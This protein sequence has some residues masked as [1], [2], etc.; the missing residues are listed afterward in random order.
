MDA[1][2]TCD[3]QKYCSLFGMS[4]VTGN[5]PEQYYCLPGLQYPTPV[6]S[7]N[8]MMCEIGTYCPA[9]HDFPELCDATYFCDKY[10]QVETDVAVLSDKLCRD[11]FICATGLSFGTPEDVVEGVSDFCPKGNWCQ[12]GVPTACLAGTY[13]NSEQK[14]Q[15]A[16]GDCVVCPYG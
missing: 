5:C 1:C 15:N 7:T 12:A 2:E 14:G 13:L 6:D 9:D 4:A 11:G 3:T 16:D 10:G 8:G